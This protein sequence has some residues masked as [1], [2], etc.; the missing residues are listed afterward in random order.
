MMLLFLCRSIWFA[1]VCSVLLCAG[2]CFK[3]LHSE[4]SIW[5]EINSLKASKLPVH[6]AQGMHWDVACIGMWHAEPK[7]F[8]G[9]WHC[10]DIRTC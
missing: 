8:A 5:R 9:S 4:K 10:E 3:S 7:G 2:P 6:R 1:P